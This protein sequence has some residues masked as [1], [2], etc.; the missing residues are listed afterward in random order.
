MTDSTAL[1]ALLNLSLVQIETAIRQIDVDH[2]KSLK[3]AAL[4]AGILQTVTELYDLH[5]NETVHA[6]LWVSPWAQGIEVAKNFA[7]MFPERLPIGLPGLA[8]V[9]VEQMRQPAVFVDVYN[10]TIINVTPLTF[11]ITQ[12]AVQM[13]IWDAEYDGS[14]LDSGSLRIDADMVDFQH[15]VRFPT[16]S[17]RIVP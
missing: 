13:S 17:I 6:N 15:G 14:A 5:E 8:W 7:E 4:A 11:F 2:Q 10:G 1:R 16:G 9:E 12:M 3:G